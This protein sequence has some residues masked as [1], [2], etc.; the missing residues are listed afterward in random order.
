MKRILTNVFIVSAT[1]VGTLV[2]SF[3]IESRTYADHLSQARHSVQ[4]ASPFNPFASNA[5]LTRKEKVTVYVPEY[6]DAENVTVY[7]PE[8][9]EVEV[10]ASD[11]E[12]RSQ[13]YSDLMLRKAQRMSED[14]LEKA[15]ADVQADLA[16][17]DEAAQT[18]LDQA[19]EIL[20]QLIVQSPGTPAAERARHA[21]SV[22]KRQIPMNEPF[23]AAP[24]VN[25]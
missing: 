7:V 9:R 2:L 19:I 21:L 13:E 4:S 1:V 24:E 16:A 6:R 11:R 22:L 5:K 14:E 3:C 18:Q 25:H 10:V 12:Q 15:I 8:E 23:Y 20:E 17:Q